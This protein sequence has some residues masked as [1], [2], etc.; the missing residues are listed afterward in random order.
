MNMIDQ[1]T[2]RENKD[3]LLSALS[4]FCYG[5]NINEAFLVFKGE[6]GNGKGMLMTL[7]KN[8]LGG[9]YYDL[10]SE[11]LTSHSKGDGRAKPELAQSRWARCVMFSEPDPNQ[12]I[13][14]TTINMLTGRD[15][16]TVR[17]LHK[18]PFSYIP[19][20][21]LGGMLNHT[22]LLN[23]ILENY[24]FKCLSYIYYQR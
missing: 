20:F 1:L 16:I 3:S 11:V 12:L 21:V 5:E 7:V 17:Q 24:S 15:S 14:K 22:Q 19:K 9:Y 4:L 13:V 2:P 10:P 6:G 23:R 18:E 8:T